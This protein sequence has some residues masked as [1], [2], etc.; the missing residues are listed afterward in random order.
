MTTKYERLKADLANSGRGQMKCFGNSMKPILSNPSTCHYETRDAYSVGDI[1]FC[2]V[3]GRYIDAHRITKIGRDGR[4][5]I[6]N[7]HGHENG[8]TR[9]IFGRVAKAIDTAGNVKIFA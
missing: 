4:Y 5:M 3:N 7:N 9:Q 6:A 8:W 2:R 1:V